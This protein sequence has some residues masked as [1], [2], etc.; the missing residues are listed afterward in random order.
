VWEGRQSAAVG[1]MMCSPH[2]KRA[3]TSPLPSS[4]TPNR[5]LNARHHQITAVGK[6]RLTTGPRAAVWRAVPLSPRRKLTFV[7]LRP[8]T[9]RL[10]AHGTQS[11]TPA[12]S[13]LLPLPWLLAGGWELP[14][15][16]SGRPNVSHV[17]RGP[18]PRSAL[19]EQSSQLGLHTPPPPSRASTP[20]PPPLLCERTSHTHAA[21]RRPPHAGGGAHARLCPLGRGDFWAPI[22]QSCLFCDV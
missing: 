18:R 10:G 11:R 21:A 3:V 8:L 22:A 19:T 1:T 14:S 9:A 5:K 2:L 4:N 6:A 12:G 16:G 7:G 20:P 13:Q 15:R 17:T